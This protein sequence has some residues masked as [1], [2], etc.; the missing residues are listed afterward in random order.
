MP[1]GVPEF[2]TMTLL[3]LGETAYSEQN[4]PLAGSVQSLN[5]DLSVCTSFAYRAENDANHGTV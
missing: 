3:E 2:Y 5:Q 1:H 4:L